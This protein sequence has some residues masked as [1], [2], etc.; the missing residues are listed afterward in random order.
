[1][2]PHDNEEGNFYLSRTVGFSLHELVATDGNNLNR[3]AMRVRSFI[4]SVFEYILPD[5]TTEL[6]QCIG[7]NDTSKSNATEWLLGLADSSCV[8]G[9]DRTPIGYGTMAT[10]LNT[11]TKEAYG[12]STTASTQSPLARLSMD[13]GATISKPRAMA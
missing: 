9:K 4:D 8:P 3:T 5:F 1:M 11:T 7:L 10:C 2:P 13:S 6:H 12:T